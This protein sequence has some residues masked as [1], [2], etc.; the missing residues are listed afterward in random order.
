MRKLL[1]LVGLIAYST[2]FNAQELID[3]YTMSYFDKDF[4]IRASE[5]EENGAYSFYLFARSKERES[6]TVTLMVERKN[7]FGFKNAMKTAAETYV[8][9]KETAINNNVTELNKEIDL[10]DKNLKYSTGFIYGDEWHFDFSVPLEASFKILNNKYLLTIE[11]AKELQASDNQYI[12]YDGF[13]FVFNS[14][15]EIEEF[16]SK[17]SEESLKMHFSEKASKEDIFKQ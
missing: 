17:V 15:E 12:D 1:L 13:Y 3:T 10:K 7:I 4:D 5:P 16:I 8:K 6:G 11:N 2:T 9:W 14:E